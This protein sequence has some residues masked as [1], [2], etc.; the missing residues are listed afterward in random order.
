MTLHDTLLEA[1][2]MSFWKSR[3][4]AAH[5]TTHLHTGLSLL[6]LPFFL[7]LAVLT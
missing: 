3:H 1:T 7:D 4:R 2:T 5:S 6:F